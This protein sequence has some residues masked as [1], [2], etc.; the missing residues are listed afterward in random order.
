MR[1]RL[2]SGQLERREGGSWCPPKAEGSPNPCLGQGRDRG[3]PGSSKF[4]DGAVSGGEPGF[5]PG[6]SATWWH[7]GIWGLGVLVVS[8]L[9]LLGQFGTRR[10]SDGCGGHLVMVVVG[11]G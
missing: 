5:G 3:N 8:L 10:V 2:S 6:S 11:A 1:Q 9:P 4:Q 7:F